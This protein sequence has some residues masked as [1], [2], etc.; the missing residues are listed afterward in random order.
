MRDEPTHSGS[1]PESADCDLVPRMD[2]SAMAETEH[3]VQFYESDAFLLDSVSGYVADGLHS[4]DACIVVSTDDHRRGIEERLQAPGVG[5][6][7]ASASGRYFWLDAAQTLSGFMVEG[8]PDPARFAEVIGGLVTRAAGGT[9]RV[10]IFGEMVSLLCQDGNPDAAL[11]LEGLWNRLSRSHTFA[12]YCA[13][14]MSDF[15]DSER[16][17][18]LHGVCHAHSRVIPAESYNALSDA[19]ERL[20]A[21]AHM[22]QQARLLEAEITERKRLE[23]RL[24]DANQERERLLAR[25]QRAL[26][27]AEGLARIKDEF[28]T[29]VS[30]ELRTP[31]SAIVGWANMLRTHRLD[32][33]MIRR[34]LSIIDRNARS[35]TRLIEELLDVSNAIEGKLR[36]ESAPVDLAAAIATAVDS[37]QLAADTKAIR[38]ILSLDPAAGTVL[39]DASR[40]QQVVWNLLSNAI[41]FTP[42]GGRVDVRLDR[43]GSDAVLCVRDTGQGIRAEFLPA[44]FGRFCQ[45]DGTTTRVYGGLGLGLATARHLVE[46]HGGAIHAESSGEGKGAAFTVR[47]PLLLAAESVDTSTIPV[48]REWPASPV[49][50]FDDAPALDGIEAL[51]VEDD[52]DVR[53]LLAVMLSAHGVVVQTAASAADALDVLRWFSPDV[54]LSDMTLSDRDGGSILA[55]LK[56]RER[57]TGRR[58]PAV[59]LTAFVEVEDGT[60]S[61]S[62]G[63]DAFVSKPVETDELLAVI[64]SVIGNRAAGDGES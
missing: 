5:L 47:L 39:G 29:T 14:P 7:A 38:L 22:Q 26:A 18:A 62:T 20:R 54:V 15:G 46:L 59:A 33:E 6:E 53:E 63:F 4:G 60:R 35:E 57:D 43:E 25:E 30:H 17:S 10:R 12:L 64:A 11:A 40:L 50:H 37:I 32:D 34:G 19:Q 9:R 61:L 44:I 55:R 31:L 58:T 27:E 21:V 49:T 28:L 8:A 52:E 56:A 24:R 23:E 2:W 51:L 45:A 36:L 3:F 13:Y 41:K 48:H 16:T 42:M 1:V